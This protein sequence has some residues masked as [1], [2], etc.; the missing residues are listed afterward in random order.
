[1]GVVYVFARGRPSM[2]STFRS[3]QRSPVVP[4]RLGPLGVLVLSACC[5]LAAGEL[6]VATRIA[7]RALSSTNRLFSMTRHFVWLVPLID[8]LLFVGFG[9]VLALA[10]RRWP[11]QA[12]WL[13]TRLIIAWAVLPALVEAGRQIH[14]EAWLVFALGIAACLA[15]VLERHWVG[16]RRRLAL[17]VPILLGLVLLQAGWIFGSDWLKQ[18]REERRPWPPPKSANVLLVVLDTVRADHLSLYGYERPTSPQLERLAARGTRFDQARAAAPWTLASHASMFTGRWTHDL[19]TGWMHPLRGDVLTVAEYLGSLGY[20]TAGFVGNTFYCAYDSGLNRGF[21]R[22]QDYVLDK[23]SA[24]RTVHMIDQT[25]TTFG[26]SLPMGE[27]GFRQFSHGERKIAADV[28]REFLDWLSQRREPRRPFFAFL[29]YAD[30]HA[31]YV[32]P[33][34]EEYRFGTAPESDADFLFL[35]DAWSQVDKRR[36]SPPARTLARDSYDNCLAYIDKCLGELVGELERRGV[37]EETLVI[38]AADHGEGLG[39]HDLFDH[40][41][42]LYR[43]E[44]R[45]P[46]LIVLPGGR[47][48]SAVS[49][50]EFVSLRDIPATVADV[51]R[52]EAKPPFPGRTLTRFCRDTPSTSAGSSGEVAVL[53]ELS[54]P[55]PTDPNQGRSPAYRGPLVSLALGDFVYIRNEG[56][57]SEELFNERDDPY[58]L[59]NRARTGALLPLLR[60]FR[61]HLQRAKA[62]SDSSMA[63][64][65][66]AKGARPS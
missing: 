29:N 63:L 42:S 7:Y 1:M 40:G 39:E 33:A 22:Y 32:L 64:G 49:V 19:A 5:G 27:R 44:I 6:E 55:N 12:G 36:I 53:S 62:H 35:L 15:P 50:N 28:N 65:G 10:T 30:A 25:L 61:D 34:G 46:L 13:S 16:L 57:G 38:V 54:S 14:I 45:V 58:E 20:A 24:V 47:G 23:L 56:D 2:M 4:R 41:E 31:P 60:R 66:G 11:R 59:T 3:A 21:T 37:L 18:W 9:V 43:T 8:L 51:V 48:R 26:S 52:P 17:G